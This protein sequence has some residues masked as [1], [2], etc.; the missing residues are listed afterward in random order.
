MVQ[1][2][3]D[4]CLVGLVWFGLCLVWFSF[5]YQYLSKQKSAVNLKYNRPCFKT[6]MLA[7]LMLK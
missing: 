1:L 3:G 7:R 6:E 2:I 5:G 4:N